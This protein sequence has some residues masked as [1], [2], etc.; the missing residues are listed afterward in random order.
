MRLAIRILSNDDDRFNYEVQMKERRV[1]KKRRLPK[2]EH[3][4]K[5]GHDWI[6][7]TAH[8]KRCPGCGYIEWF[9]EKAKEKTA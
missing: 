1:G 6:P 8:V 7:R 4:F 2:A 3:C 9:K 5:C